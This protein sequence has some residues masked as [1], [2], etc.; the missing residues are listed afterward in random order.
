MTT[1]NVIG[2]AIANLQGIQLSYAPINYTP[3]E[4]LEFLKKVSKQDFAYDADM[5]DK[6]FDGKLDPSYYEPYMT[7]Q[8]NRVIDNLR[9]IVHE[10][11]PMNY[12]PEA[13]LEYLRKTTNQD[14]GYDADMWQEYFEIF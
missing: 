14:F 8:L 9:G 6:F 11:E 12:T 3:E 7:Y 4:A 1:Y 2:F 13:A 5:W 10:S